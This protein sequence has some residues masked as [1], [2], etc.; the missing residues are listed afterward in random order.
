M[1]NNDINMLNLNLNESENTLFTALHIPINWTNFCR[2]YDWWE[3]SI[4]TIK[5]S[6][7]DIRKLIAIK[8]ITKQGREL[9]RSFLKYIGT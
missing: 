8:E 2:N 3:D 7:P 9:Q 6:K 1:K 4:F 5:L